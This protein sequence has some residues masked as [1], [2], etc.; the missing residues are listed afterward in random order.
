MQ[1]A[2]FLNASLSFENIQYW[3]KELHRRRMIQADLW[4]ESIMED[5]GVASACV[6]LSVPNVGG[7]VLW[8]GD[9]EDFM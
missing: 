3:R 4:K 7:K 6:S 9:S 1:T 8:I 2:C 5:T